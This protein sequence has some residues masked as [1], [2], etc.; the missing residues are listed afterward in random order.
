MKINIIGHHLDI[1][2]GIKDH[3]GKKLK[4]I[5]YKLKIFIFFIS[6]LAF[7][8]KILVTDDLASFPL[9]RSAIKILKIF[10]TF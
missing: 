8:P 5:Q 7:A 4:K 3:I 10:I 6:C 2:D 1:T 9:Y